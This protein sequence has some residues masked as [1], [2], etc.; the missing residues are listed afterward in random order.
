VNY[1]ELASAAANAALDKKSSRLVLM[2]LRG[3]SDICDYQLI[4]S[5]DNE[6]QTTAIA[7]SIEKTLRND[8]SV[9]ASAIEGKST[10]HWILMDYG[11]VNIHIFYDYL[12]DYYALEQVWDKAKYVA[13]KQS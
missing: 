11:P 9:R 7:N 12:R 3:L 6:R 5:G 1:L 10:G 2:D 4:C 13:I 8:L